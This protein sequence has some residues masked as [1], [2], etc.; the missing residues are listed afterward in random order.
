VAEFFL[1]ALP[2]E[3][4]TLLCTTATT[5]PLEPG[6]CEVVPCSWAPAP[7]DE[8]HDIYVVVDREAA[9]RECF[10]GNNW[11]VFTAE[12]IGVIG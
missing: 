9:E 10:E 12:C 11:S 7:I 1:D 3:G 6:Q 4:G 5:S 8:E 2:D